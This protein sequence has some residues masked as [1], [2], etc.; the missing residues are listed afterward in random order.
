[1]RV[2]NRIK[3]FVVLLFVT[4]LVLSP[5]VNAEVVD[6]I[7]AIVNDDIITLYDLKK[8]TKSYMDKINSSGYSDDK[9]SKMIEAVNRNMLNVLI[10]GSLTEQEARR[11]QISISDD[12]VEK[13]VNNFIQAKSLTQE[14]FKKVL[15]YEGISY[16]DYTV[17]I[18]KQ[19]LQARIINAAVKSKVVITEDD[20]KTYY[21][22]NIDQYGKQAKYHLRN[23]VLRD[24]VDARIVKERL[25]KGQSFIILAKQFSIAPNASEGGDLG[26]F[27]ISNF[28]DEIKKVISVMNKGDHSEIIATPQGLQIFFVQDVV[29]NSDRAYEKVS[30]E[31]QNLLYQ[32]E[33]KKKFENWLKTLK[34]N[35]H[36]KIML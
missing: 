8:H 27:N 22:A 4:V 19:L 29:K 17:N 30:K 3:N 32:E 18:R 12:E 35:A 11:Y 28:S 34:E 26:L 10:D 23:I 21:N 7:V 13:A 20:V 5:Y 24:P 2:N 15:E 31:I 1:M 6:K 14:E 25:E 36:I 9:R 16:S 33:V